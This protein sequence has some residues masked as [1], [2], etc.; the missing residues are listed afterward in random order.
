MLKEKEI[1]EVILHTLDE[2]SQTVQAS[3]KQSY[4]KEE[5][6][7]LWS[8]GVIPGFPVHGDFSFPLSRYQV[9][10]K[11]PGFSR[12]ECQADQA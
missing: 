4:T 6:L 5:L 11:T 3:G 1:Q 7:D 9:R 8:R 2:L 12:G 10:R